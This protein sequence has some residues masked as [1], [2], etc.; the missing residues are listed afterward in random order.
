MLVEQQ[1]AIIYAG[2]NGYL[3]EVPVDKV[4][5]YERAMLEWMDKHHPDYLREIKEKKDIGKQLDG[6][7][8]EAL[9]AFGKEFEQGLATA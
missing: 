1:I 5:A 8:Q 6:K 9:K 7:L 4:K 3:D 2:A